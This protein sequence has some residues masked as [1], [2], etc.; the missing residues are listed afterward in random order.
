M[1]LDTNFLGA[2][3]AGD[4]GARALATE[5]ESDGLPARIPTPVVFEVF[6]GIEGADEPD[7]LLPRYEALFASK[8]RVELTDRAA[9][10][11]G[12]LYARHE[13]S[14]EKRRLD[15]VDAMVAALGLDLDEPVVTNDRAF[16]DVDG[17]EIRT[18]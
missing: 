16:G 2:L 3:D 13:A 12:R 4:A 8:P 9:R 1:I 18:Y 7:E 5:L 14:D 17:L 11:G 10:R 15:L 6:Y